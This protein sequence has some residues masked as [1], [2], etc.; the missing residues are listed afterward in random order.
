MAA[1]IANSG[2][3][4]AGWWSLNALIDEGRTAVRGMR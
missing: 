3:I 2:V 1:P 4:M